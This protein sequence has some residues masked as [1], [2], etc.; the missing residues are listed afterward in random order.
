MNSDTIKSIEALPELTTRSEIMKEMEKKSSIKN[1]GNNLKHVTKTRKN[2]L[3]T[4]RKEVQLNTIA[5]IDTKKEHIIKEESIQVPVM[6]EDSIEK[7]RIYKGEP[8]LTQKDSL[9][10]LDEHNRELSQKKSDRKSDRKLILNLLIETK[11]NTKEIL[12]IFDVS[13]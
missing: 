6:T 7:G 9:P 1:D 5:S 11:K 13:I 12:R 8:S 3:S 4:H 2:Q 10:Q